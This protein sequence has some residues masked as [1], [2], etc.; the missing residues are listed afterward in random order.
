MPQLSHFILSSN[1]PALTNAANPAGSGGRIL[2]EYHALLERMSTPQAAPVQDA[3]RLLSAISKCYREFASATQHDA[4]ELLNALLD[5]LHEDLNRLH[6]TSAGLTPRSARVHELYPNRPL[7]IVGDLF[8]G[9]IATNVR[10]A[11]CRNTQSRYES[12]MSLSLPIPAGVASAELAD[13]MRLYLTPIAPEEWQCPACGRRAPPVRECAIYRA[14]TVMIV[15]L[16]RFARAASGELVKVTTPVRYPDLLDL[17]QFPG[18]RGEFRLRAVVMHTGTME[19]GHYTAA[20]IDPH[21]GD[22]FLFNDASVA[23]VTQAIVHSARA[24]VLFY[25]VDGGDSA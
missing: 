19:R 2:G 3:G 18:S 25:A 22:W 11:A 16:K 24:Y 20:A 17:G 21:S 10:C 5:A 15:H 23:K 6:H 1:L 9:A 8:A 13:C 7:S 14:P 12:F 4:Q